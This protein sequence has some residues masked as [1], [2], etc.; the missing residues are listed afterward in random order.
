MIQSQKALSCIHTALSRAP[1]PSRAPGLRT[2]SRHENPR[3]DTGS[4]FF[5]ATETR[6]WAVAHSGLL[7]LQFLFL[8]F[9]KHP[10][11]DINFPFYYKGNRKPG[12]LAKMY[13]SYKMSLITTL[14]FLHIQELGILP[15]F[16]TYK[17]KPVWPFLH[18]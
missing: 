12:K 3:H 9:P 14:F 15:K 10:K 2:M 8:S 1:R 11:F 6:K 4:T 18:D 16:T 17:T 7:H 5:V 13:S